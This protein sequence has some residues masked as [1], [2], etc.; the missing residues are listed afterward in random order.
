MSAE[1]APEGRGGNLSHL[2]SRKDSDVSVKSSGSILSMM[3]RNGECRIVVAFLL[4]M[5]VGGEGLS[6]LL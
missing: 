2:R 3:M 6:H 4:G 1:D 5:L